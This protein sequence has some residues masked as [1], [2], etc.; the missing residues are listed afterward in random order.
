MSRNAYPCREI[1]M[2]ER[3][4][5][6]KEFGRFREIPNTMKLSTI[7]GSDQCEKCKVFHHSLSWVG[8]VLL[9]FCCI[10]RKIFAH[11][12][13]DSLDGQLNVIDRR[14]DIAQQSFQVVH[15]FQRFNGIF[16]VLRGT[17]I[18]IFR[19]IRCG[20]FYCHSL[21]RINPWV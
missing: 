4:T 20:V 19:S 3:L 21:R 16:S 15:P 2:A 13:V 12:S 11:F 6:K 1:E 10:T 7:E 9:P 5:G 14:F 8:W 17:I 18:A